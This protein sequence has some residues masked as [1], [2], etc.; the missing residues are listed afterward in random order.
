MPDGNQGRPFSYRPAQPETSTQPFNIPGATNPAGGMARAIAFVRGLS[1][2]AVV[3]ACGVFFLQSVMPEG[4]RPSDLI[5]ATHGLTEKAEMTVKGDAAADYERKLAEA[6]TGGAVN[7]QMEAE[8]FRQQQ[9]AIAQSLATRE[10]AAQ[11]ADAACLGAP[12]AT[13]FMGDTREARDIQRTMQAGCAEAARIRA[14]MTRIQAEAARTG[15][16]LMQ[17]TRAAP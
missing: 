9:E 15:S 17:R 8:L 14:E 12:L 3:L 4:W 10:A 6:R 2:K 13:L 7:W 16:A 5:G 11:I 1:G